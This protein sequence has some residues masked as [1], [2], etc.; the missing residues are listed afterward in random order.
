VAAGHERLV[1]ALAQLLEAMGI[2]EAR[3]RAEAVSDYSDGLAM[4]LLTARKGQDIDSA[5]V[6]RSIRRL[7]EG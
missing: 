1:A 6:A 5:T 7:L 3:T 4:H 2:S